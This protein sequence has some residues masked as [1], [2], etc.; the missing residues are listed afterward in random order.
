MHV[1]T[2]KYIFSDGDVYEGEYADD[3]FHGHGTYRY[4]D[5]NVFGGNY[6]DG[7]KSGLGTL[8]YRFYIHMD[9]C[10]FFCV[11]I[12]MHMFNLACLS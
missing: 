11:Y 10:T 1:C 5:G 8:T 2:G 7:L 3:V 6:V 4:A 9:G 12:S